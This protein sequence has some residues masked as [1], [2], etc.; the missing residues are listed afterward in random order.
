VLAD[1]CLAGCK[2]HGALSVGGHMLWGFVQV[3][4]CQLFAHEGSGYVRLL[5]LCWLWYLRQL[6]LANAGCNTNADNRLDTA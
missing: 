6:R 3:S 1:A 4:T 5:L 2:V